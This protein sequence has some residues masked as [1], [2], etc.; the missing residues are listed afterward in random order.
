MGRKL[1][2]ILVFLFLILFVSTCI[3][4]LVFTEL[5]KERDFI[6]KVC[7]I[8]FASGLSF[9]LA[10]SV[11]IKISV[12]AKINDIDQNNYGNNSEL[13]AKKCRD[14]TVNQGVNDPVKIVE[15]VRESL[16]PYQY[17]NI[18]S[19]ARKVYKELENNSG[20]TNLDK[21][22]MI[23]YLSESSNIT[24]NDIQDIWVK[25]LL[26]QNKV[27]GSVSKRTL[28]IVKNMS[29]DDA[30]L[31]DKVAAF[32]F[33]DG[34]IY[35]DLVNSIPFIEISKLQDIGLLKSS[36]FIER[37][38]RMH[39]GIDNS[40]VEGNHV[41]IFKNIGT[42]LNEELKYNCHMLTSEGLELKNALGIKIDSS[43]FIRFGQA[44]KSI[45]LANKNISISAHLIKS[46]VGNNIQYDINDLI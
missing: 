2:I 30:L 14:I 24:N 21:D 43:D 9:S 17:E 28:D 27:A 10:I 20:A 44:I 29:P 13:K 38:I 15:A 6:L 35:K 23:K 32:A 18:E 36:D 22:F 11:S 16:I 39:K 8:L 46:I 45:N 3:V 40:I 5:N 7:E 19:I 31:F 26:Q 4:D 41:I 25:L 12:K 33:N 1:F 37:T 34:I 42:N